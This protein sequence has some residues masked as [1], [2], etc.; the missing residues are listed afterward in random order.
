MRVRRLQHERVADERE[1]LQHERVGGP[2]CTI[3]AGKSQVRLEALF[4]E[5]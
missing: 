3:P 4:H 5:R 1:R 2:S